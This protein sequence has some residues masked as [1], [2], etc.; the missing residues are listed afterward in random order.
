MN[1]FLDILTPTSEVNLYDTLR[2]E[3]A[4]AFPS[5]V[6]WSDPAALAK[7]V[8]ADS[9]I[10][11]S[12]R[13]MPINARGLMR[14]VIPEGG[15]ILPDG[16]QVRRGTWIGAPVQAVHMDDRFYDRPDHYDPFRFARMTS[17]NNG[18]DATQT[19]E[20]FLRWGHGR[21]AWS[22]PCPFPAAGL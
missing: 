11:E 17:E 22:V 21:S 9:T 16:K 12:L 10:R 5:K 15:L 2:E 8:L 3:A 18:L 13:T 14:E 19:S 4:Q 20:T 1:V 6:D 7:L